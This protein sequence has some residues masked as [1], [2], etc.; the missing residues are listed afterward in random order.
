MSK[1]TAE[2]LQ[3]T[4][5]R[6]RKELQKIKRK[7]RYERLEKGKSRVRKKPEPRPITKRATYKPGRQPKG[8]VSE[9][10]V[11]S[12]EDPF[13]SRVGPHPKLLPANRPVSVRDLPLKGKTLAAFLNDAAKHPEDID[14]LKRDD[15]Y[16]GFEIDGT[17][18]MELYPDFAMLIDRFR[19]SGSGP[20]EDVFHKRAKSQNLYKGFKLVRVTGKYPSQKWRDEADIV[21]Q[22]RRDARAKKQRARRK[23]KKK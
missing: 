10:V 6:A 17:R 12:Y 5:D 16:W 23:G 14:R 13:V 20:G 2:Q 4:I 21:T 3:R 18:S 15:E 22:K 7:E 19:D 1:R 9:H 8:L 11:K